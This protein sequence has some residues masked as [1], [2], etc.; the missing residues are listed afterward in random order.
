MSIHYLF[1]L[2]N[3]IE[4]RFWS[5]VQKTDN[6]WLWLGCLDGTGY[7]RIFWKNHK[8]L[9][10]HRFAYELLVDKIP[11]NLQC[12]HICRN[13]SCVNP[14]H[15]ELVT[16]KINTLRGISFAAENFKKTHCPKGHI[17]SDDNIYPS[18]KKRGKRSCKICQRG[19]NKRRKSLYN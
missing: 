5:K 3:N 18:I 17:L 15:I 12:D 10:A 9:Q 19:R 8:M 7:G 16:N 1:V 13:R 6:C 11:E 14:A 2:E 4:Q